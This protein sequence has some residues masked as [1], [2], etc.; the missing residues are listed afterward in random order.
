MAETQNLEQMGQH[1]FRG[2]GRGMG[3]GIFQSSVGL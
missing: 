1:F 2:E 3:V